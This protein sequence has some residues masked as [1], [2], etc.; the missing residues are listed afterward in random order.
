MSSI[1]E[2]VEWGAKALGFL[3]KPFKRINR[4]KPAIIYL[5]HSKAGYSTSERQVESPRDGLLTQRGVEASQEFGERLPNTFSYRIFHSE[6][7][8]A[9][10]TAKNIHQGIVN[11]DGDSK[12]VGPQPFLIFSKSDEAQITR[13]FNL[14]RARETD[15]LAHWISGRYPPEH[16]EPSLELAQ[17]SAKQVTDNLRDAEP[18]TID[19]Y[20]NHDIIILPVMFHWFGVYHA[21]PWAGHLDGFILQLYENEMTF[22]DKEGEHATDYPHWWTF[23]P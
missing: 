16:V 13:Y 23:R 17:E 19:I 15:F 10:M 20:V 12:I 5:R 8:R 6:Y 7:P 9:I 21:Y 18:G 2:S 3:D 11:Q 1:L 14:N 4:D 22:I